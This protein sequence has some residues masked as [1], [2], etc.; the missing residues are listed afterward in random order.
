MLKWMSSHLLTY[1]A[2]LSLK[3][4]VICDTVRLGIISFNIHT[5]L[6]SQILL[7]NERGHFESD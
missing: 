5:G 7:N 3:H 4:T 1:A 6:I 2:L